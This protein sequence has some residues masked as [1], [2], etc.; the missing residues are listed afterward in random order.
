MHLISG[1][2]ATLDYSVKLSPAAM[3]S[4][5]G[6]IRLDGCTYIWRLAGGG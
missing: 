5:D 1:L 4:P 6:E 2:P 3:A